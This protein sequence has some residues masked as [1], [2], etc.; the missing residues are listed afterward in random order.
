[1]RSLITVGVCLVAA[2]AHGQ[3]K[4]ISPPQGSKLRMAI[5]DGL[6]PIWLKSVHKK[7]VKFRVESI[8]VMGNDAFVAFEPLEPSG[9]PYNWKGTEFETRKKDGVLDPISYALLRKGAGGWK[10]LQLAIG[11]TDVAYMEWPEK[12]HAPKALFGI[13]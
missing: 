6:R 1:M 9:K 2:V 8:R 5:L 11:P 13:P 3:S 12:Y 4:P 10:V 7:A